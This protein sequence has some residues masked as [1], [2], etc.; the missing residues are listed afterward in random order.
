MEEKISRE[1]TIESIFGNF[2]QKGQKLAQE[3]TNT[4]LHCV[5]CQAATWETLEAGMLGHGFPE[6]EIDRLIGR[7]NE[8]LD[9][10][11]D[12]TTISMTKR[13][14]EKFKAILEDEGKKGWSL[15]FGDK[16]GGCG[17]FE[18]I[19]DFSEK[20]L[21]GDEL[22]SSHGIEIHVD[23]KMA[24]RLL[25]SEIDFLDGLQGAG[26]KVTN[27]NVKGSCGCGNSQSY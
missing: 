14:A 23:K 3:M 12:I 6:E 10:E 5:G 4:G 27:P 1:M 13:A 16:P 11:V 19:I 8:I 17:G 18:Y 21:E 25:G 20:A 7:L 26:F 22:F 15:R 24:A 2:P 9:E